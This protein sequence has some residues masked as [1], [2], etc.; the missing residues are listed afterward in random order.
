MDLALLLVFVGGLFRLGLA[1]D[2]LGS[3]ALF[4]VLR[5]V[6]TVL[7]AWAGEPLA[8]GAG[9]APEGLRLGVALLSQAG[10][11]LGIALVATQRLPELGR[12]V[13]PVVAATA[14]FEPADPLGVRRALAAGDGPDASDGNASPG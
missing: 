2:V 14:P 10:V 5:V 3:V 13:L 4:F 8:V 6:G 1:T 7:G 11:A 12:S 9:A